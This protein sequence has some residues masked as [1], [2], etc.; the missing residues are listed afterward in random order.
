MNESKIQQLDQDVVQAS[1][2]IK[3]LNALTW[4][5]DA[6]EKFLAGWHAKNPKLPEIKLSSP[7][8]QN[9]IDSLHSIMKRC[10]QENPVE[11][12]LYETARSYANAGRMLQNIGTLEF[13]AY[14]TKIY[15]RPD[16]IYKTQGLSAV[17]AANFF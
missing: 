12:F 4:P 7:D 1:K 16:S 2:K 6:E 8:V 13:T 9:S 15:G 17:D 3:V 5:A 11:K 10:D 14:S